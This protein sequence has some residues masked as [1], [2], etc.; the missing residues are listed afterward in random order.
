M[1]ASRHI[2]KAK[3]I[4]AE[5]TSCLNRPENRD[6]TDMISILPPTACQFPNMGPSCFSSN[7]YGS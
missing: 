7:D 3:E 4:P 2:Q 5:E 6:R 1:I